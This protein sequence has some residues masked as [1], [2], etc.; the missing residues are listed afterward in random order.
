MTVRVVTAAEAAA[1]DAAAIA[2]GTPSR[3]LMEAAGRGAAAAIRESYGDRLSR[4]VAILAGPGN[5][6]GDGWVVARHLT[7]AGVPVRVA[8]YGE[9]RTP[10]ARAARDAALPGVSLGVPDGGEA[11]VVDAL[12]G[13][14]ARGVPDGALGDAVDRAVALRRGGAVVVALDVPT[15]VDATT[16]VAIRCVTA[17]LTVTFGTLKRAHVVARG[18]CGAIVVVDIGLGDSAELEDGAPRLVDECW[19]ASQVPPIGAESHKGIRRRVVIAG[20]GRGMAGAPMLA[21]RAA[22]RSGVGMVRLLVHEA[23]L[24]AVQGA[25]IEATASTWPAADAMLEQQVTGYAHAV[26]AGPGLGRGP[27]ERGVVEQLL[28]TWRGP[29]VLDADALNVFSGDL[30]TL[31][32][33]LAGRPALLTPH[34]GELARLIDTTPDDVVASRFEAARD[35]ARTLRAVVLLKGVPTVVTAPNGD[36]LV[37]A[38]GTPVLAAAGS[39]D[40][41]GGIAVTLLAQ[42]GDPFHSAA[43]AAWIHGRAAELANAGRPVRGVVL[44]DVLAHLGAAWRLDGHP[45]APPVLAR[46]PRV[47]DAP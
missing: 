31:G 37:S 29:V 14:G 34:A 2:A 42:T 11:V 28:R 18:R 1:R 6:G 24:S 10:D 9:S 13:T 15:G 7:A 19:V 27:V 16:G 39:G 33:L 38:A 47:G 36:R 46:L 12:L 44:D 35:L 23:S 32:G 4:G 30:V 21:A 22:M 20:G 25:V 41:L 26:L 45:P 40:L 5:N 43:V 3:A 8:E 17:D